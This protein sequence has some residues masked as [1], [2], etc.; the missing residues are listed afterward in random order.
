M[1][2]SIL[3]SSDKDEAP[4]YKTTGNCLFTKFSNLGLHELCR[5]PVDAKTLPPMAVA[6]RRSPLDGIIYYTVR[7]QIAIHFGR[8]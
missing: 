4:E 3:Y 2:T 5:L 1:M 7:Y 8:N 6:R